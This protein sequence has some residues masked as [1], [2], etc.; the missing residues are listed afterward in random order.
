MMLT[1]CDGKRCAVLIPIGPHRR[2]VKGM[3]CYRID[4]AL[5]PALAIDIEESA[6]CRSVRIVLYLQEAQWEGDI[7]AGDLF[8]CDYCIGI[9]P[10]M[11]KR[12]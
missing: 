6:K 8:D 10:N 3:A 11:G 12:C 7:L 1:E 5:G 4:P 9:S 2:L